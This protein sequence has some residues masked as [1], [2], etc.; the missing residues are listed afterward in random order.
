MVGKSVMKSSKADVVR[1]HGHLL[2]A[3]PPA[4]LGGST[5]RRGPTP[6]SSL[7]RTS[8]RPA[9]ATGIS[10]RSTTSCKN[11]RPPRGGNAPSACDSRRSAPR[12]ASVPPARPTPSS[13]STRTSRRRSRRTP[14]AARP[15]SPLLSR[16]RIRTPLR[17]RRR[18]D[19]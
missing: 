3:L 10:T 16:I 5:R 6:S 13:R 11:G 8:R 4:V 12:S 17:D 7:T 19:S 18:T 15:P 9:A 14:T 1:S 2:Y